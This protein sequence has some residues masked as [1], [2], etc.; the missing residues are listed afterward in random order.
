VYQ[1]LTR[2]PVAQPE[3]DPALLAFVKCHITSF[4]KWDVLRVLADQVGFW[5]DPAAV[6][7]ETNRAAAKVRPA[8]DELAREEIIERAGSGD[9]PVYRLPEGEPTTVVVG[10]LVSKVTR[11]QD[12]RRIVVAH[13]LSAAVA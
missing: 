10:R 12:L 8:L 4:V 13:I 5:F 7:H 1:G 2:V 6:A 9:E 11:S 3:L